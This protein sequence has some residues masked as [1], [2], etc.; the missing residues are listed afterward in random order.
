MKINVSVKM[1][2][3]SAETELQTGKFG[4][5]SVS[6]RKQDKEK[7]DSVSS[8]LN[9]HFDPVEKRKEF[10]RKQAYKIVK[11]ALANELKMDADVQEYKDH[12]QRLQSD[13]DRAQEEIEKLNARQEELREKG[14][15]EDSEEMLAL[16]SHKEPYQDIVNQAQTGMISDYAVIRGTR[17]ERLKK[18]PIREAQ[19]EKDDMLAAAGREIMGM[20]VDEAKDYMDEKSEEIKE[21]AEEKRAEKEEQQEKLDTA[22]EKRE[23]MEPDP[24]TE[25]MVQ[26]DTQR[27]DYQREIEEMMRKMKLMTEDIK[28]IKV[29]ETF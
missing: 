21:K 25:N 19:K 6:G 17:L 26:L 11:D 18:D 1:N 10:A 3:R 20:L 27:D 29:D 24:V 16:E 9:G 22:K 2:E 23:E 13:M 5:V 14:F 8:L 7:E 28:G 15:A 4:S 12:A